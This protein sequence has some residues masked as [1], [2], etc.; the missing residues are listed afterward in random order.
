MQLLLIKLL[1]IYLLSSQAHKPKLELGIKI[2]LTCFS[3][4]LPYNI[5]ILG[6][7][8]ICS[9]RYSEMTDVHSDISFCYGA[10]HLNW[11]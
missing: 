6:R 7:F 11:R 3:S 4:P 8:G 10:L 5:A 1:L 9:N 2:A